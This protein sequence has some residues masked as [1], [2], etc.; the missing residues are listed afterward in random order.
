MINVFAKLEKV[1]GEQGLLRVDRDAQD[2]LIA[3]QRT[4]LD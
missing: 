2:E 1:M 3:R 4:L